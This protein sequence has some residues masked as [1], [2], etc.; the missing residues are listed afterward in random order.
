MAKRIREKALERKQNKDNRPYACA[1]YISISPSKVGIVLDTVRGKKCEDA[2]A[3]LSVLPN[4]AASVVLKLINSAVA[5]A[6]HNKGM[7]KENLYV[8]EIFVGP[9]PIMKRQMA[10]GK[11]SA[12][13]ILKRSSHITVILDEIKE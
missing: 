9:G 11:G 4:N 13:R 12:S 1:K 8:A 5:N 7:N 2:V 6:E 10:R 3:I